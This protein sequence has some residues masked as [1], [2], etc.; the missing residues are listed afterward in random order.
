[1]F[2]SIVL[3]N[4]NMHDRAPRR[5]ETL[6]VLTKP[7]K[8]VY[9]VYKT[10]CTQGI[11]RFYRA[12][13][14]KVIPIINENT[15][16]LIGDKIWGKW[17]LSPSHR[18]SH[19]ELCITSIND[20]QVNDLIID[21]TFIDPSTDTRWIIDYKTSRMRSGEDLDEFVRR[22]SIDHRAQMEFYREAMKKRGARSIKCGL[23]FTSIGHFEH[24]PELDL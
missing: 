3:Y 4:K 1:M 14:Q 21:R 13:Q 18:D 9:R 19:A 16:N 23:Y 5:D 17:I 6:A 8:Q 24:I 11:I 7:C 20:T 22:E 15:R 2:K 10:L 12:F